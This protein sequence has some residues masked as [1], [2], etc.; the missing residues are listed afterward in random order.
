MIYMNSITQEFGDPHAVS[1]VNASGIGDVLD[2]IYN[3]FPEKEN[4]EEDDGVIKVALIGNFIEKT[5]NFLVNKILR[6]KQ[7]N[8]Q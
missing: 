8:C 4:D 5:P 6:R 3:N 2:E 1:S 7:G